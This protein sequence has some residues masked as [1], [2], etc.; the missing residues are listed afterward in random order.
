M[1]LKVH[2]WQIKDAISDFK[3]GRPVNVD[4]MNQ[5]LKFSF[6]QLNMTSRPLDNIE[7]GGLRVNYSGMVNITTG[8]LSGFGRLHFD[9]FI[10]DGQF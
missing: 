3:E 9:D 8:M 10:W 2:H 6:I 7:I 1:N 4:D 5:Q